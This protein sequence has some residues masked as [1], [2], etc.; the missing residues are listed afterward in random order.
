MKSRI[1]FFRRMA[2]LLA[3]VAGLAALTGCFRAPKAEGFKPGLGE[4]MASQQS[5]HAK[6]WFAGE[7]GNWPLA[8]Y[9]LDEIAE[10][11]GDAVAFHPVHEK[12]PRP[13][14]ELVPQFMDGPL[15][16]LRKA[17]DAHDKAAFEKAF[18]TMTTGCN[19]CHQAAEHGFNVVRRPAFPAFPN[20]DF[21]PGK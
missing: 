13:L 14:T 12:V 10:G 18:D 20:Q 3:A 9:E 4:I 15:A 1:I 5:R 17:V 2:V 8:G 16:G 11:F 19:G 7:N 21:A 6:L